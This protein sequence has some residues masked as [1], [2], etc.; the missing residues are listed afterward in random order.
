M[1]IEIE[2]ALFLITTTIK[3]Q[4]E[5]AEV[6]TTIVLLLNLNALIVISQALSQYTEKIIFIHGNVPLSD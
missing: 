1:V 6:L 5:E 4:F 2:V 3:Y